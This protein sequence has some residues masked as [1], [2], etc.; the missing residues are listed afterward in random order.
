MNK[1]RNSKWYFFLLGGVLF[2]CLCTTFSLAGE[3]ETNGSQ[4]DKRMRLSAKKGNTYQM[5][6]YL[7]E[8]YDCMFIYDSRTIEN[9]HQAEIKQGDYSLREAITVITGNKQLVLEN[10]GRY[11]SIRLPAKEIDSPAKEEPAPQEQYFQI[12]GNLRDNDTHEPIMFCSVS[13]ANSSINTVSNREGN[14]TIT[15]HDSL[16]HATI[17]FSHIGYLSLSISVDDLAGQNAI[18][19]LEPKV[20][21]L[22]DVYVQAVNTNKV[23]QNYF[24]NRPENY[25]KKPVYMHVFYREGIEQERGTTELTEA[26]FKM[27]KDQ[28]NFSN[29]NS[30]SSGST[31]ADMVKLEKM[32]TI[33]SAAGDKFVDFKM[34]SGIQT[35]FQLDVV[36]YMPDF[37]DPQH[38]GNYR[39]ACVGTTFVDEQSLYVISFQPES[40]VKGSLY[41]GHLYI[42]TETYALVMIRFEVCPE[43]LKEVSKMLVLKNSKTIDL[44]LKRAVYTV[45]YKAFEG[46]CYLNYIRVDIDFNSRWKKNSSNRNIHCWLEMV[47]TDI[48]TTAVKPF[49]RK[50][51]LP[52]RTIFSETRHTYDLSFWDNYTIIAPEERF[53]R[54]I[55][56]LETEEGGE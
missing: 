29:G 41:K 21:V 17:Q 43:Q 51:R 27:Y 1:G 33:L 25:S 48:S 10:I 34:K 14:F 39:Y 19:S 35:F 12:K 13:V 32:R 20:T 5:L 44:S 30:L 2:F 28:Y 38:I 53:M 52:I 26:V 37:L 49:E 50:E 24:I 36:K 9:N 54:L 16:K 22:P 47:A 3:Q 42:D 4:L 55:H 18:L 31:P 8:R 40:G 23:L 11:V 7:S 46:I 56:S 15:L 6:R 45:L